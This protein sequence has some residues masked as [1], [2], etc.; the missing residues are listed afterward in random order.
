MIM[1]SLG[2]KKKKSVPLKVELVNYQKTCT[3]TSY[4]FEM[5]LKS[6][7]Y[8]ATS[9]YYVSKMPTATSIFV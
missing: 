2:K 6:L 1:R 7:D 9:I 3:Y 8:G 4:S 5:N